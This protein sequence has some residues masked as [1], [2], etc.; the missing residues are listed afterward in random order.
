M[1]TITKVITEKEATGY[2]FN[3]FNSNLIPMSTWRY[4]GTL[5]SANDAFLELF[6]YSR[7]EFEAGKV[8]WKKMTPEGQG[9]E[10]LDDKCIQELKTKGRSTPYIKEFIRKDGTQVRVKINN[11]LLD[12]TDDH[13]LGIFLPA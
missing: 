12:K 9:F 2:F 13:G 5:T 6:G 10:K 4:D 7:K 11:I 3:M 1:A 8:N